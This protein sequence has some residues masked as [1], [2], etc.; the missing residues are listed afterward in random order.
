MD[1]LLHLVLF[2]NSNSVKRVQLRKILQKQQ[3]HALAPP[4]KMGCFPEKIDALLAVLP[5]GATAS[6]CFN[7][8][9]S[10]TY[11]FND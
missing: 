11:L 3:K 10:E 4:G 1:R 5:S 6:K 9:I 7:H 2:C 8:L